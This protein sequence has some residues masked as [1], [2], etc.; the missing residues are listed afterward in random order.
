MDLI[1]E[2]LLF[3]IKPIPFRYT[4]LMQLISRMN[5]SFQ[6]RRTILIQLFRVMKK[7]EELCTDA[8]AYDMEFDV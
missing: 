6:N 4:Q 8:L 3:L 7:R 1:S 5:T 2:L